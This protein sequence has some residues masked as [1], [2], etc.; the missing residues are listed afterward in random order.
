MISV[1]PTPQPTTPSRQIL[2]HVIGVICIWMHL[3]MQNPGFEMGE[4]DSSEW[5]GSGH[6]ARR[7]VYIDVK[8]VL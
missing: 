2:R 6:F 8:K 7:A 3:G 4:V 5:N 1:P